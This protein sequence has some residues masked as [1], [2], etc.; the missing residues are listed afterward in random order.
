MGNCV[1]KTVVDEVKEAR[2]FSLIV[3]STPDCSH[4][5]QLAIVLRY[6]PQTEPKPVERLIKLLPG[7]S[8]ASAALANSVVGC[9]ESLEINIKNCR[10]QSYDNASNMSGPYTGL[11][12][13]IKKQSPLAEYIPCAAHSLNLVGSAAAECCTTTVVFFGFVQELYNYFSVSTYRWSILKQCLAKHHTPVV[14]SL[15]ETRWSARADAVR[16]LVKG[17]KEIQ[18]SLRQLSEDPSVKPACRLEAQNLE[19]KFQHFETTFLLLVW[20]EILERVDKCSK[21]MQS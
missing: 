14:K 13:R 6:V 18:E 3:D 12:A 16:A 9:L 1:L 15:S 19:T 4:T 5:D 10:G 11:Q 17:Y 21:A 2:Y 7:I 20:S 8:H